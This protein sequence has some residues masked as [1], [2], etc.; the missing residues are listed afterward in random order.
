MQ[1][2]IN[3]I[4]VILKLTKK[5]KCDK[6]NL[7]K[8]KGTDNMEKIM[9]VAIIGCGNISHSHMNAYRKNKNIKVIACADINLERAQNYAKD[10]NILMHMD[11]L[12]NY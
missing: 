4:I 5:N 3:D 9:N 8:S 12:M 2:Q 7:I 6:I 11:Q 10:Y 1:N